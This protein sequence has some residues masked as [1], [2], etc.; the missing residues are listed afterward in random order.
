MKKNWLTHLCLATIFVFASCT[1]DEVLDAEPATQNISEDFSSKAL[2][3]IGSGVMMQAFYWDVP[4]GGTWWNKVKN[5]AASWSNAGI[6]AIWLPPVSKA[7]N[8]A[9]SMGYDPFDYYDFGNYNQMGSTETRFGSKSE[10]QSLITTAH[11][12]GLSV[13]A[14]IVINHN[15]GG[16]SEWN[17]FSNKN[18]YT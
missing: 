9:F 5:K 13:I 11:N 12:N 2:K 17:I 4:A 10:L 8:G 6:D 18:T 3:P 14:D 15:S 1:K 7:Q 16:D